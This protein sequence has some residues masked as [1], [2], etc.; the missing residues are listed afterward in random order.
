MTQYYLV[1][2]NKEE[3]NFGINFEL[4][5]PINGSFTQIASSFSAD[6]TEIEPT[7]NYFREIINRESKELNEISGILILNEKQFKKYLP[8]Y[9]HQTYRALE[10]EEKLKFLESYHHNRTYH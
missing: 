4:H 6:E 7:A 5:T 8:K 9:P 2:I 1:L 3:L 10:E